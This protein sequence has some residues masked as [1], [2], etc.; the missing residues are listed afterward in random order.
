MGLG[1]LGRRGPHQTRENASS[2]LL[3]FRPRG[4]IESHPYGPS[5]S[6]SL[7]LCSSFAFSFKEPVLLRFFWAGAEPGKGL[8]L[9]R[10]DKH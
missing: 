4:S 7:V 10:T 6:T 2:D 9:K 5:I 8:G 3:S 1:S